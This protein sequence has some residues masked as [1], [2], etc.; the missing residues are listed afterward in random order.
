MLKAN[1]PDVP[2]PGAGLKTV[3]F[4]LPP[5]LI[6]SAVMLAESCVLPP[7]TNVVGRSVLFQRTT[8]FAR[9][10][11][12][13]TIRVKALPPA[14]LVLG[15]RL[16][17]VGGDGLLIVKA[18]ALDVPPPGVGLKTVT[19]GVP[20]L[21]KSVAGIVALNCVVLPL[22]NVV[23]RTAP[24]QSTFEVLLKFVPVTVS[25][26]SALPASAEV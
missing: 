8:E 17:T 11:A 7:L 6:S 1:A 18:S 26:R 2:P 16:V 25:I 20:A 14:T 12:P 22:T 4:A 13:V 19:L 15:A 24:F 23:V 21:T 3:T 9:K 5:V 10:L